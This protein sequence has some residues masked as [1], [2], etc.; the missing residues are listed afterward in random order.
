MIKTKI[1]IEVREGLVQQVTANNK[2]LQ[3]FVADFD[4]LQNDSKD[5]RAREFL[6]KVYSPIRFNKYLSEIGDTRKEIKKSPFDLWWDDFQPIK[7]DNIDA[8]E[9]FDGCMYE[10]YGRDMDCVE[11][12]KE[13]YVWT[14][15]E[16]DGVQ[17]VSR[18][19]RIVN[20]IG[21]FICTKP[22]PSEYPD[23]R[24]D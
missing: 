9:S 14:L 18:G 24:I 11:R 5:F 21:Y 13:K 23:V 12:F 22:S 17:F 15:L 6:T 1:I 19:L 7:N 10:T 3:V 2:N 16:E 20:R 8:D 4:E